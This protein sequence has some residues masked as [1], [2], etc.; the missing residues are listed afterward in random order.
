MHVP[1]INLSRSVD[2]LKKDVLADW[3]KSLDA[4]EFVGGEGVNELEK[5]LGAKLDAQHVISCASG[6][7]A[8]IVGLQAMGIKPGMKVAM[9]NMTFWAPYEAIVQ[10]GAVPVLIDIDL[11][12]LQ[13]CYEEFCAAHKKFRFDGAILVHLF[14]W[15]SQRLKEFRKYCKEEDIKLIEDGAQA[16]GVTVDGESVFKDADLATTSFYPAKVFGASGD[17]GAIFSANPKVAEVARAL[18]N[19]GRAGHYT[20][21]Y[22]GWNSR[23]GALQARYL[24]QVLKRIDQFIDSRNEAFDFYKEYFAPHKELLKVYE[25]PKGVKGNGYLNVMYSHKATGDQL[26]AELKNSGIGSARTYPQTMDMQPPAKDALRISDLSK[27]RSFSEYVINLPLFAGITAEECG[28]SSD[29]LLKAV[30]KNLEG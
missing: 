28:A 17:A 20:Y 23:L 5:Q 30:K 13:M 8:L 4:C 19:H 9:P 21:D 1:F 12:D 29:A 10:V 16:F 18:C 26:S 24:L 15:T 14:G 7:D 2:L 3:S 25:P 6:T 27:S 22:V 11:D